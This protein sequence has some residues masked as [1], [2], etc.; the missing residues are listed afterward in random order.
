MQSGEGTAHLCG[1]AGLVCVIKAAKRRRRGASFGD[2]SEISPWKTFV[3]PAY[4]RLAAE[5]LVYRLLGVAEQRILDHAQHVASTS[6]LS[7]AQLL[8]RVLSAV[9]VLLLL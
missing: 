7:A 9:P 5:Q 3:C 4:L 2:A 1:T 6:P 8:L